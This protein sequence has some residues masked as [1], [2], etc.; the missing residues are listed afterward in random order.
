M[1]SP[2]SCSGGG[3]YTGGGGNYANNYGG[4]Y[5]NGKTDIMSN[6]VVDS[7]G[8]ETDILVND[9][10]P[11]MLYLSDQDHPEKQFTASLRERITV[12][13]NTG[14]RIVLDYDRSVSGSHCEIFADGATFRIRDLNST[15]GTYVDGSRVID[16]VEISNGTTI[17]LGRLN[18]R[19]TI[20]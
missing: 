7:G 16:S 3:N 12:G 14:N 1:E 6:D 19:V 20:R 2:F 18:F 8:N 4:G 17:R 5:D 13:H 9:E 15:N 10:G 11:R